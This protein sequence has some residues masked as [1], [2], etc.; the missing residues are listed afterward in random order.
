MQELVPAAHCC[1]HSGAHLYLIWGI[2]LAFAVRVVTLW[3]G[4][5][6]DFYM[7]VQIYSWLAL[8][9]EMDVL[10]CLVTGPRLCSFIKSSCRESKAFF[11]ATVVPKI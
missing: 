4:I 6:A 9:H 8:E 2:C 1:G 5:F 11:I 3:I 10:F 7:N